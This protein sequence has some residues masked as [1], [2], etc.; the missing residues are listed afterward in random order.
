MSSASSRAITSLPMA[1]CGAAGGA[2]QEAGG[3]M[4]AQ[5]GDDDTMTGLYQAGD[6]VDV[7]MDIVREPMQEKHDLAVAWTSFEVRDLKHISA[8]ESQ[9][10]EPWQRSTH[11]GTWV[12]AAHRCFLVSFHRL[13]SNAR[14]RIEALSSSNRVIILSSCRVPTAQF[15]DRPGCSTQ[16][17]RPCH[18]PGLRRD[19]PMTGRSSNVSRVS[20]PC[21]VSSERGQTVNR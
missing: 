15:G 2:V 13:S 7:A 17:S 14:S 18:A 4:P 20:S 3:S 11:H 10:F 9:G 12:L 8:D 6:H 5:V 16:F 21:P 19:P 1:G